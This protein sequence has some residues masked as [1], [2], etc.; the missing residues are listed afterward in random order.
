VDAATLAGWAD[1]LRLRELDVRAAATDGDLAAIGRMTDLER[2]DL[3]GAAALTDEAV[4]RLADL[5]A[6]TSLGLGGAS[7]VDGRGLGALRALEHLGHDAFTDEGL[8]AVGGLERLT[9]L[10]VEGALSAAGVRHLASLG[11]LQR[12]TLR[13][14]ALDDAALEPLRALGE[15]ARVTLQARHGL[16]TLG[17][18]GGLPRLTTLSLVGDAPL[19][20]E[21]LGHLR[22]APL[23]QL[24]LG[25]GADD[26]D[27][28]ARGL[29]GHPTLRRL[30]VHGPACADLA[31]VRA[32]LPDARVMDG[33][34]SSFLL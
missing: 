13:A 28:L 17:W 30:I 22:R 14:P 5:P 32:A 31:G 23:R 11:R 16:G 2:L 25:P 24:H 3:A 6:L 7:R 1:G 27:A 19:T 29:G 12:L 34:S 26:V 9:S 10:S 15:L 18:L 20:A 4:A 21:G 8:A 33:R